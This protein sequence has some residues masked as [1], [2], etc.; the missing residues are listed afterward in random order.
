MWLDNLW[1][2]CLVAT[3]IIMTTSD[4]GYD[5]IKHFEG[6]EAKAYQCSAGVWTI[7]WGHTKDV[8]PTDVIS[9]AKGETLLREDVKFAE[10][11]INKHNLNINQNQF[12]ALV[13]FTFN[14]GIGNFR[15]STLLR[16]AKVNPNDKTIRDE[17]A[18]WKYAGKQEL[19]GLRIRRKMEADLYFRT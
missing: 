14:I 2:R 17:F 10:D 7:G 15:R 6:F 5:I 9:K 19:A 11:E 4:N 13:S 1:L 16:K 12:D 3:T 18:R 8:K